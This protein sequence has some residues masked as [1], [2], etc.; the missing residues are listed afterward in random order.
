MFDIWSFT[1]SSNFPMG[2]GTRVTLELPDGKREYLQIASIGVAATELNLTYTNKLMGQVE[3]ELRSHGAQSSREALELVE[4]WC[5]L[6]RGGGRGSVATTLWSVQLEP[7][8]E[9]GVVRQGV[10]S[11]FEREPLV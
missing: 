8:T 2:R 1:T 6:Q 10:P 5:R 11:R 3:R 9:T 7:A 4:A